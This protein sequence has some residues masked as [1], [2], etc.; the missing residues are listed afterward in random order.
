VGE[1]FSRTRG[2][3]GPSDIYIDDLLLEE[4]NDD[5]DTDGS[6]RLRPQARRRL[7]AVPPPTALAYA[8]DALHLFN[9]P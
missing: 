2:G 9:H 8:D 6:T 3:T 7:M 1:Y 5:H 4:L